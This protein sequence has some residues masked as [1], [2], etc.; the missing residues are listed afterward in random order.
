MSP[1]NTVGPL[2]ASSEVA[3]ERVME[4]AKEVG[5]RALNRLRGLAR[6]LPEGALEYIERLHEDP[7][8]ERRKAARLSDRSIPVAVRPEAVLD[9]TGGAVRDHSPTGLGVLLPCPAG[10][11]TLLRVCMPAH[12]GGGGW[13]TVEV[14]HCRKEAAGWVAGCELI[15]DR[16]PI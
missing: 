14:K 16:P 10:V 12:L 8:A 7:V 13:V 15:G 11:G 5:N 6:Q 3:R 4:Q 2:D 1:Q 9:E